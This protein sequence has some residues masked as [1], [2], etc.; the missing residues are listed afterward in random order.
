MSHLLLLI[1]AGIGLAVGAVVITKKQAATATAAS[2]ATAQQ[3]ANPVALAKV[4]DT[5][6]ASAVS[7]AV[8]QVILANPSGATVASAQLAQQTGDALAAAQQ[9]ALANPSPAANAAVVQAGVNTAAAT[10]AQDQAGTPDPGVPAGT[11]DPTAASTNGEFGYGGRFGAD[12]FGY[13]RSTFG[14]VSLTHA[15]NFAAKIRG[16][17]RRFHPHAGR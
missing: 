9:A 5:Q 16:Q 17:I 12:R 4:V 1:P 10:A 13:G 6:P 14:A 3:L 7:P 2:A 8:Q 11:V 15:P